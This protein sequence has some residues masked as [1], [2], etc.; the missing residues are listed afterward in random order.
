[1]EPGPNPSEQCLVTPLGGYGQDIE[2]VSASD[3]IEILRVLFRSVDRHVDA[4][5]PGELGRVGRHGGPALSPVVRKLGRR[6][7]CVERA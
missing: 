1:M 3:E 5:M 2:D 7:L 6:A 4:R